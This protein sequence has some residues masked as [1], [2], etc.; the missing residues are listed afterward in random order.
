MSNPKRYC[1]DT[2]VFIEG[3]NKY[4]SM[5]L[6]PGY[7][8][9]LDKLAQEDLVF[10]PIEVKREIEK[11]DDG[12]L[13]KAKIKALTNL[14]SEKILLLYKPL[15]WAKEGIQELPDI[16]LEVKG[17]ITKGQT[18]DV[19]LPFSAKGGEGG[20]TINIWMVSFLND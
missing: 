1:L 4:Y 16:T 6:C 5:G 2:N 12:Y 11:T 17:P 19:E 18:V 13:G 9:I 14:E 20:R 15:V 10:A 3:W 7:W 8:D